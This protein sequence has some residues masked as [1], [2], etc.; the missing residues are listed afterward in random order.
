MY[1]MVTWFDNK[2]IKTDRW[3]MWG[4]IQNL[5]GQ[6][7]LAPTFQCCSPL[8]PTLFPT[9]L[10]MAILVIPYEWWHLIMVINFKTIT[11]KK[12]LEHK[13]ISSCLKPLRKQLKDLTNQYASLIA[14]LGKNLLAMQETRVWSVGLEDPLEEKMATQSH[15]LA[16]RI[17]WTE[18]PGG[19]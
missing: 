10:A 14:Y 18:G 15:I 5:N 11:C 6:G 8:H 4:R 1:H 9:S 19:L 16:W 2:G 12:V 3:W 17:L 13:T 7:H